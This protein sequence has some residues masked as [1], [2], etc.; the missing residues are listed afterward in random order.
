M[1]RARR[2]LRVFAALSWLGAS[3]CTTLR[4]IPREQYASAEERKRVEVDTQDGQHHEFEFARFGSDTLTGFVRRDTEGPVEEFAT[5]A[6]PL[7]AVSRLAA[8]RVDWYRT[9]LIGGAALA[10]VILAALT[11]GKEAAPTP[12]PTPCPTEPC[13]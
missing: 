8:R 6:I 7:D 9:G 1:L 11:R 10:G 4:E 3:G 2:G 5:V 13:P 12:E